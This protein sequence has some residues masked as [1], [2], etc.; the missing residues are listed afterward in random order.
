MGALLRGSPPPDQEG[1]EEVKSPGQGFPT[2]RVSPARASRSP[3][4]FSSASGD[5]GFPRNSDASATSLFQALQAER[6]SDSPAQPAVLPV[7]RSPSQ[8]RDSS[9]YAPGRAARPHRHEAR[10]SICFSG[11]VIVPPL[12]DSMR[13]VCPTAGRAQTLFLPTVAKREKRAAVLA[14]VLLLA[15]RLVLV[16]R[17]VLRNTSPSRTNCSPSYS[18]PPSLSGKDHGAAKTSRCKLDIE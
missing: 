5:D 8:G 14:T 1:S 3:S 16:R 11:R 13:G 7:N 6:V 17:Y 12:F 4:G 15:A 9:R 2:S 10:H 18:S